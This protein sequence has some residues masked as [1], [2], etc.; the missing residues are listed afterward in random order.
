MHWCSRWAFKLTFSNHST[1]IWLKVPPVLEMQWKSFCGH[2][3]GVWCLLMPQLWYL[4]L[5]LYRYRK[6]SKKNHPKCLSMH[7]LLHY[8]TQLSPHDLIHFTCACMCMFSRITVQ[9]V[10]VATARRLQG[11][12]WFFTPLILL[13]EMAHQVHKVR[14][15]FWWL[16]CCR[17]CV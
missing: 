5:L 4:Q 9:A 3:L 16:C 12:Y 1:P 7:S 6:I 13:G 15:Y 8:I 14:N 2:V 10:L 11:L 17:T